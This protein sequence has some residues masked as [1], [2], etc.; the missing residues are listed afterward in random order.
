MTDVAA[1]ACCTVLIDL[2]ATMKINARIRIDMIFGVCKC[3]KQSFMQ[4]LLKINDVL[5][6]C[7]WYAPGRGY[8]QPV[9][10]PL[11]KRVS[12]LNH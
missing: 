6:Y 4:R 12:V 3:E 9:T 8:I 1:E 10:D 5:N 2:M 11:S 7:E